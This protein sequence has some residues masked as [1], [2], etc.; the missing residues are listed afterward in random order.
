MTVDVPTTDPDKDAGK[1][2]TPDIELVP[3][4]EHVSGAIVSTSPVIVD[5]DVGVQ[6]IAQE[7]AVQPVLV[8]RVELSPAWN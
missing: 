4:T 6:L 7:S 5:V 8:V 2:I 3:D 1:V